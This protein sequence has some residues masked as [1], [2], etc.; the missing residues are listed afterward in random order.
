MIDGEIRNANK[1]KP[2]FIDAKMNSLVD[3]QMID[4]LYEASN[5]GVKIRLII[6][7]ICCLVPGVKGQSENIQGISIIDKFLEH[8]RFFIFH[9]GGTEKI[10]MSSADWMTRNLDRRIETAFP[11]YDLDIQKELKEMFD[12]QWNDNVKARIIG[13]EQRNEMKP[14][15]L[16]SIRSQFETYDYLRLKG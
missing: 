13:R 6:R 16:P 9:N 4:K 7:G 1:N 12:I 5:A 15:G 2:A 10:F 11:I 8:S 3:K 14:H